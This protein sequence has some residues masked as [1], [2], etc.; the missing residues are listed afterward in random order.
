MVK[1]FKCIYGL[2]IGNKQNKKLV[3]INRTVWFPFKHNNNANILLKNKFFLVVHNGIQWF[4]MYFWE[5]DDHKF[6][7]KTN[8]SSW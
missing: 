6:I 5:F 8:K 4:I 2:N 7:E 1:Q 3:Y